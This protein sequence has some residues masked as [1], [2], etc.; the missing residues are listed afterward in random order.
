MDEIN[1]KDKG[2]DEIPLDGDCKAF[3]AIINNAKI[4]IK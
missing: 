3:F 2:N 4:A 1:F